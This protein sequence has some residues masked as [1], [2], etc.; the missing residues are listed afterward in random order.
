LT[1]SGS[2]ENNGRENRRNQRHEFSLG[3]FHGCASA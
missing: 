1:G 2:A 3:R